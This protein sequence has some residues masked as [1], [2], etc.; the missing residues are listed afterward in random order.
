MRAPSA[1]PALSVIDKVF[2]YFAALFSDSFRDGSQ[3]SV[4]VDPAQI[5]PATLGTVLRYI[6]IGAFEVVDPNETLLLLR[7]A[8][9]F[10][11]QRGGG[12][13]GLLTW[14]LD[15]LKQLCELALID[16]VDEDCA[17]ALKDVSE[18]LYCP[19]LRLACEH[20]LVF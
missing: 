3:K 16:C 20:A 7:A 4:R 12:E 10:A 6:Y 15:E 2:R 5:S 17:A 9:I 13:G 8:T 19:R 18:R 1:P 14:Q 11:V